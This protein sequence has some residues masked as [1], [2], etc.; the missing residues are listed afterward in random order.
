MLKDSNEVGRKL[1]NM[2]IIQKKLGDFIGS[3]ETLLEAINWFNIKKDKKYIS[4]IY[5]TFGTNS[6][7]Q[8]DFDE[9][10]YW[11]EKAIRL[12]DNSIDKVIYLN[13]K[14]MSYEKNR[15]Y[16]ETIRILSGLLNDTLEIEN[17]QKSRIRDNLA[18]VKFLNNKN[19]NPENELIENLNKRIE[20]KDLQGAIASYIHLAKYNFKK[21]KKGAIAYAIKALETS[22]RINSTNGQLE[23]LRLLVDFNL[24]SSAQKYI[25][26]YLQMSDSISNARLQAK[27][28][29]AKIKYDTKK[30]RE[31]VLELKN[32]K[33]EGVLKLQ[34]ETSRR[35]ILILIA[36]I[37]FIGITSIILLWRQRIKI[38]SQNAI[39]KT[40]N[41]ISKKVHD[42]MANDIISI[43]TLV[44]NHIPPANSTKK[45]IINMLN[46]SYTKARDI[47][48]ETGSIIFGDSFGETLKNL[49]MQ[50]NNDDIKIINAV[51]SIDDITIDEYKK[52]AIYRVIQ[53]LMVNMNK[54]SHATKVTIAYR[55]KGRYNE[56][57]Y[58]DN[59]IGTDHI[60]KNRG[61]Q[62]AVT[63]MQ[64]IGGSFSFETSRG[65]GFKAFLKFKA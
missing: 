64:D 37:L 9:S 27:N 5:N 52:N 55:K 31:K 43:K 60:T 58:T 59:G 38:A 40:E 41:R 17:Y 33:I 62:N 15:N 21:S 6:K 25:K 61:L 39:S 2:G 22:K 24:E 20:E 49:L 54:H 14:A 7:M 44:E 26:E 16:Q 11:Y 45:Q 13:N 23:S 19:Y 35:N 30:A 57:R 51:G 29:F 1:L 42:E 63:R 46:T 50:Y 8:K 3:D 32:E 65:N 18:Y 12:T 47:A 28:Q 53:E 4:S 36:L 34:K 56:I 48:T 10:I